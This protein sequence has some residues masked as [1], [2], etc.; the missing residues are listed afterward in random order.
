MKA[1]R[2]FCFIMLVLSAATAKARGVL[3]PAS[4]AYQE[5]W[6]ECTNGG[7]NPENVVELGQCLGGGFLA[8]CDACSVGVG[9]IDACIDYCGVE[10]GT[11]V[12]C[13][14][15]PDVCECGPC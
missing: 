8:Y 7:N 10:Q 12:S 4:G 13:E 3:A 1:I 6:T 14:E 11:S 9:F 5:F 2:I 15:D